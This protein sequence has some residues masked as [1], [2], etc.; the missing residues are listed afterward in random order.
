MTQLNGHSFFIKFERV[1]VILSICG[2]QKGNMLISHSSDNSVLETLTHLHLFPL[3]AVQ[4]G[5]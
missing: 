1:V 4:E 5:S 2:N 3:L